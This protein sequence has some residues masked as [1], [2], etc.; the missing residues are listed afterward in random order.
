MK[1]NKK[2]I[3]FAAAM[4]FLFGLYGSKVLAGD[5]DAVQ[6]ELRSL[7]ADGDTSRNFTHKEWQARNPFDTSKFHI[8]DAKVEKKSVRRLAP[9]VLK[10]IF[11]GSSNP[12]AIING[13][14]VG[15]GNK[16][17][18]D[19]VKNIKV[20]SVDLV[21]DEGKVIVLTLKN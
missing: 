15:V 20:D 17:G 19:T 21:D 3:S 13:K 2:I 12:S 1:I 7:L 16:I 10:G 9:L 11:L 18:D 5:M 6:G 4:T 8:V 14:V